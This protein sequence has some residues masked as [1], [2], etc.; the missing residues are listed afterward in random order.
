VATRIAHAH[1][2]GP[3][4]RAEATRA[5][6][7]I[8]GLL[9]DAAWAQARFHA[10][11]VERKPRLRARP[12]VETRFAVLVDA[13]AL[14]VGVVCRQDADDPP[15][16]TTRAR[17]DFTM[18]AGDAISI[19][20]DAAHDH[21][22]TLG[23]ALNPAGARLDY[24][25]ADESDLRVEH[26]A[27]WQGAARRVAG[28]WS[29][30][31]RLPFA[32]LGIDPRRPPSRI[33]LNLSRDHARRNAT[34]DWAL[35]PPPLEPIAASRYGHLEGIDKAL[36]VVRAREPEAADGARPRNLALI[37]YAIGGYRRE[38][39]PGAGA[40]AVLDA[41]LDA[42]GEIGRWRGHLT[43]NTDFAEVDLDDQ[44]VNLGRFGLFL[45]EKRDFF[46]RDLELFA[47]GYPEEAQLLY[48]RRIGLGEEGVVPILAG[49]KVVGQPS[50]GARVGVLQV[51]TRSRGA[52]AWSSH[53]VAR[54]LVDLEAGSKVGLM[55]T[56]RQ[57]L[58]A[59]GDRNVVVGVDGAWRARA[60][61]LPLLVES[62]AMASLTGPGAARP[63]AATG[64][65][66][67]GRPGEQ[68][69]APG[70]ALSLSLR[71]ERWRPALSY[72]YY[73]P[74][75]RADLG[76]L[77]RVGVQ[78]ADAS[79]GWA[80]R[81]G[82][83]LGLERVELGTGASLVASAEADRLL[84]WGL[85]ASQKL[86][87]EQ[88][89]KVGTEASYGFETIEEPFTVG[90]ATT[91]PPGEYRALTGEVGLE[92]PEQWPLSAGASLFGGGYYGG[93]L[94]GSGASLAWR[95]A[96]FL[97]AEIGAEHS[98]VRF[99]TGAAPGLVDFDS[100]VVNGRLVFG[101]TRTLS[102]QLVAG[103]NLLRDLVQLQTRLRWIYLPGSDLFIVQQVDLDDDLWAARFTS[104]VVKSSFR[105]E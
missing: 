75:L 63:A 12:A 33:G 78:N 19:K 58:E 5:A 27:V 99:P 70:A 24:R 72:A 47:F 6:P 64:G 11:F 67:G 26:D 86:V 104:I 103:Y 36:A 48:S 65:R 43:V 29:A 98:V 97:R 37:P 51:T 60:R 9:D 74:E 79:L 81:L 1:E 91:V 31:L 66:P 14:Y 93:R 34:Y 76:F 73:H 105:I 23:F 85:S 88:G 54:G 94:F 90:R 41:G 3:V 100:V 89:W 59:E 40:E 21:R 92:T 8:D 55:A 44:V 87:W 22:T 46:L 2:A 45:P 69:P 42:V 101:F 30:E 4:A 84:D 17:D 15:R 20:I 16:A 38:A 7:R 10:G 32:A 57:S 95:P 18:F 25:A 52:L 49:L 53:A 96:L 28:G 61:E 56:H 62:F 102:L 80:E 39:T 83:R 82:G 68:R 35:L 77:R 13:E 50:E 71:D